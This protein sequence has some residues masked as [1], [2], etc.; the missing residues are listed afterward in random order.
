M[1]RLSLER[2][3]GAEQLAYREVAENY[4]RNYYGSSWNKE[5]LIYKKGDA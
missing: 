2:R 4:L 3:F 5:S 1:F